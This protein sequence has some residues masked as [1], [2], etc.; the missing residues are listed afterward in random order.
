MN[1]ATR[2]ESEVAVGPVSETTRIANGPVS[3]SMRL[4]DLDWADHLPF[5]MGDVT[6]ELGSFED[7]TASFF[8]DH[9]EEVFG[10]VAVRAG[11][12]KIS[13][14]RRSRFMLEMDA[15][16]F[17]KDGRTIGLAMAQSDGLV[18]L[19]RQAA[20]AASRVPRASPDDAV[21][22]A[23]LRHAEVR[24]SHPLRGGVLAGEPADDEDVPES[25]LAP[26]CDSAH[27]P[28][29]DKYP[30]SLKYLDERRRSG[31]YSSHY[32]DAFPTFGKTARG[33]SSMEGGL[34]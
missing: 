32:S 16:V 28:L 17:R 22:G 31:V 13:R 19:L 23:P 29:R 2:N 5:V 8:R 25:G 34:T 30:S 15:F 3:T 26:Q 27:G 4:W 12:A 9:Y 24:G 33:N 7:M 14:S 10:Q 6:V 18:D 20:C 11:S 1:Q 21:R